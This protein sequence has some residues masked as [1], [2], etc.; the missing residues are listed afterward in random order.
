MIWLPRKTAS[1]RALWTWGV[2]D[3]SPATVMSYLTLKG[4]LF[5]LG[6]LRLFFLL[7]LLFGPLG[8][9]ELV[10]RDDDTSCSILSRCG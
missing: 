9:T 8:L 6:V 3:P 4:A 1:K 7:L 10:K 5:V 2:I